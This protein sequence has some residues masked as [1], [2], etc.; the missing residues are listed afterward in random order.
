MNKHFCFI[1]ETSYRTSNLRL[2]CFLKKFYFPIKIPLYSHSNFPL[3]FHHENL[4]FVAFCSHRLILFSCPLF[5][6]PFIFVA[7]HLFSFKKRMQSGQV[8]LIEK[9]FIVVVV[10]LVD[11][12]PQS[13]IPDRPVPKREI[14]LK[15]S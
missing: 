4:S 1:F 2:E 10:F 3:H 13:H 9:I 15:T 5:F 8:C 14:E 11:T 12:A 6:V 7:F